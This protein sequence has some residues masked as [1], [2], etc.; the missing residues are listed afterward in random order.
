[1]FVMPW[2][3]LSKRVS[4]IHRLPAGLKLA[5]TLLCVMFLSL[6]PARFGPAYAWYG[7]GLCL[8]V[9]LAGISFKG[10]L[11]RLLWLEP[12]ALG[13]AGL[14]FLQ[15]SGAEVFVV[16]LTKSTLCLAT[17][18]VLSATTSFSDTLHVLTRLRMPRMLVTT[19]AL[20]YRYLFVLVQELERMRRA[21]ASRTF[22]PRRKYSWMISASVVGQ[23]FLRSSERAERIYAAMCSRGWK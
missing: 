18:I 23:L 14:A 11:R 20:M 1:M 21:R 13:V 12:M 9:A 15:P 6:Q 17:L 16:L 19:V 5:A 4:C 2:D 3:N 8:L 7:A 22:A 10:L